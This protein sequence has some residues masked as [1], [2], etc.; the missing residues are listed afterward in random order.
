M[1]NFP[2]VRP[3]RLVAALILAL[4]CQA[5]GSRSRVYPVQG[6]VFY[7][8]KPAHKA[9]VFLIP[10]TPSTTSKDRPMGRVDKD[11]N[12]TITTAR[13]NG[14]PSGEYVVTIFWKYATGPG[15]SDEVDLLPPRYMD[16]QQ[17]E[18]RATVKPGN[19]NLE[20]FQLAP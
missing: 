3:W 8:G 5:C 19:N 2:P 15:D 13:S 7:E 16:P 11:G 10:L 9:I 1:Q 17:S 4:V 14:D 18:L 6:S 20:P 12:F